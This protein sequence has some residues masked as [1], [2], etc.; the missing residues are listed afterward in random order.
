MTRWRGRWLVAALIAVWA[1]IGCGVGLA[2]EES[3]ELTLRY[4]ESIPND[5]IDLYLKQETDS[6][7]VIIAIQQIIA[8]SRRNGTSLHSPA[9]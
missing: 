9:E 4:V 3:N 8:N 7:L 6:D 1:V 5:T 2:A